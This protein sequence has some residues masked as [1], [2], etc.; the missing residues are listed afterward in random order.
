MS[1]L[2]STSLFIGGC[3]SLKTAAV[4]PSVDVTK[5]VRLRIVPKI[6]ETDKTQ[7]HSRSVTRLY[8]KGILMKKVSED[9]DFQ[10]IS[11]ITGVDVPKNEIS[12]K[13]KSVEKHGKGELH[14]FAVPEPDEILH[15]VLN[16]RFEVVSAKDKPKNSIFY[17]PT[18]SVPNDL[19]SVG[20]SWLQ[21]AKWTSLNNEVPLKMELVSILKKYIPCGIEHCAV[22]EVSGEVTLDMAPTKEMSFT[23][24]LRGF[25]LF[26][27]ER[28]TTIWSSVRSDQQLGAGDVQTKMNSCLTS[29]TLE[30]VFE[31]LKNFATPFCRPE[32]EIHYDEIPNK[33]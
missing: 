30:P 22:I 24:D 7:Y 18:M 11:T 4:Y 23:S 31:G 10:V 20:D 33:I 19:V 2:L 8:Q 15:L 6:G 17:V 13:V 1:L 29:Y 5:P 3:A 12:F 21:N 32:G 25:L 9:L 26:S 27:V 14:E 16:D 28:G